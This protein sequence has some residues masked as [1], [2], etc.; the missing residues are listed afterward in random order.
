MAG[1]LQSHRRHTLRTIS[2]A[3]VWA[4][5]FWLLVS[6]LA[7]VK[8]FKRPALPSLMGRRPH[9]NLNE[10]Y[11]MQ[12]SIFLTLEDCTG[13]QKTWLACECDRAKPKNKLS[14]FLFPVRAGTPRRK[15]KT[16]FDSAPEREC[17]N[18]Y[19]QFM[20]YMIICSILFYFNFNKIKIII[21][22]VS[23]N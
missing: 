14:V 18:I 9:V 6:C 17:K 11:W 12:A 7:F 16:R 3:V 2:T 23:Q 22:Y 8:H 1:V 19:I 20:L 10:N 21:I 5:G 4:L 13:M 15:C